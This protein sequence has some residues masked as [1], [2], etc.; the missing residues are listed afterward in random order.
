MTLLDVSFGI[1]A[2]LPQGWLFM[3]FVISLECLVMTRFLLPKWY[4]RKIYVAVTLSNVISGMTGMV[5][6][7]ILNG[8]WF[9]VVWFPW[10]SKH[11][12]DLSAA[13]ALRWL[14]IFYSAAFVLTLIIETILNILF[15]RSEYLPKKI[16]LGT[17]LANVLSY[18]LGTIFLYSY[19][20][21]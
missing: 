14:I 8:G 9:L 17:L 12:L 3:I 21:H 11:E 20:F 10:V 7:M 16:L 19:S 2:F 18:A 13:G 1:F 6:S 5:I 4:N 15:L